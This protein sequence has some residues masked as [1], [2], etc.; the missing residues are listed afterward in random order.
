L[1]TSTTG[2]GRS[3]CGDA[4]EKR[5][6]AEG[7]RKTVRDMRSRF[8]GRAR[9]ASWVGSQWCMGETLDLGLRFLA[10]AER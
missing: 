5:G 7:K 2:G 9:N 8:G 10:G 4:I 1:I 6:Q 3:N